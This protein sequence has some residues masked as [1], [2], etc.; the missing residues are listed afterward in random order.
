MPNGKRVLWCPVHWSYAEKEFGIE[1]EEYFKNPKY[2]LIWVA[3]TYRD[4][5][6]EFVSEKENTTYYSTYITIMPVSFY[7]PDVSRWLIN[8]ARSEPN[9]VFIVDVEDKVVLRRYP[10]KILKG[11]D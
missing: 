1:P 6:A 9:T 4:I 7:S 11:G 8:L 5:L 3:Y 2:P 10:L